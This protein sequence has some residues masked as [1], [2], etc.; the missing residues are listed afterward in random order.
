M[1]NKCTTCGQT[2]RSLIKTENG[3]VCLN[4]YSSRKG[5]KKHR[6]EEAQIQSEFFKQVR[7]F[8]PKLP[9]KLLFA[10]P[11]GGSRNIIEARNMKYQGVIPGVADVILLIP[12]HG[13]ASLCIEF[14]TAKGKQSDEQK[15]FQRQVEACG[16]KYVVVR[17][18]TQ[19]IKIIKKY[20]V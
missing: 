1:T 3:L 11:N 7:I 17:S 16:S 20:L 13:Y 6:N 9:S 8:F 4:C 15:E 5:K 10:V 19:A 14:K 18:V 2:T 12:K